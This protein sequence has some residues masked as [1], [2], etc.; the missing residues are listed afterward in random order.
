[1][2]GMRE[3]RRL[4]S[5]SLDPAFSR[6]AGENAAAKIKEP[7]ERETR[8]GSSRQ[9]QSFEPLEPEAGITCALIE[10]DPRHAPVP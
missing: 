4:L 6:R 3:G 8:H 1:M 5:G 2:V 7:S 10:L 9:E